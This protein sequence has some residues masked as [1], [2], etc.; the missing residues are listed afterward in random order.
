MK[1]IMGLLVVSLWSTAKMARQQLFEKGGHFELPFPL[2]VLYLF[3]DK[4]DCRMR[5]PRNTT[6]YV[7][8]YVQGIFRSV[9]TRT[10]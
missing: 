5:R 6:N 9:S 8:R 2:K 3:D 10:T 7:P 4:Y 1:T